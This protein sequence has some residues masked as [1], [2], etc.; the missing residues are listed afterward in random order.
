[1]YVNLGPR[2]CTVGAEVASVVIIEHH[3]TTFS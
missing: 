1:M 2:F 3:Y